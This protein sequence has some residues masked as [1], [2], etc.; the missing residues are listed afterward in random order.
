MSSN[1]SVNLM[2]ESAV[3]IERSDLCGF[4]L[5]KRFLSVGF[6]KPAVFA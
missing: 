3:R 5:P 4:W 2:T 1:I 6:S